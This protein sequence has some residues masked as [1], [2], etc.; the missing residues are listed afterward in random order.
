MTL[1]QYIT[2]IDNR[3]QQSNTTAYS[4]LQD[5]QQVRERYL[6]ES[7]KISASYTIEQS[8]Q[9]SSMRD[10]IS[11]IVKQTGLEFAPEAEEGNVC[12]ANNNSELRDDYKQN[13]TFINL[14]DYIYAVLHSSKYGEEHKGFLKIDLEQ[15]P[16]PKDTDAFWKLVKAGKEM[17]Q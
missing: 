4:F 9:K 17:R 15:F 14:L 16:C 1:E 10:F 7:G 5:L 3:Y 8:Y 13:F 2:N 6:T 11:K 12:F